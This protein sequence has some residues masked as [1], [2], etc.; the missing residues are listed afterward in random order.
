MKQPARSSG[1]RALGA[2][3]WERIDGRV[4]A[5]IEDV[6][7]RV[8]GGEAPGASGGAATA[9]AV[10]RVVGETVR[11]EA[12]VFA[13]G[14]DQLGVVI[15]FQ[16]SGGA[17]SETAMRA[18]G[19]DRW[20]GEF[21]V[22]AEGAHEFK[23]IAWVDHFKTWRDDLRKRAEAGQ[24]LSVEFLIGAAFV[25]DAAADSRAAGGEMMAFAARL[26]DDESDA[27]ARLGAALD[28]RLAA[29][30]LTHAPRRFAVES[31][32]V[33]VWVDRAK[34]RFSSWYE[35]FPRSAGDGRSHGTMRDVIGRLDRVAS[36]GFDVLYM[37]PIHPIGR[38]F[39]KGKNNTLEPGADD[40]GSP[41]AIGG[42]QGGHDAI[43]PDLGTEADFDE[44]IREAGTRGIE[45]AMDLA[46]QCS[47]DHPY[48]RAHPEWF[49]RRPD[50]SIQYAENPPKKYQ[51][52]YPFEFEC[53]AWRDLWSE[54]RRVVLHWAERGVRIFRV[55]NP[56]TKP[57]ALWQWLI[58]QVKAEHPDVLFLAEAFTRPKVMHRLG[59]VGFTQSYTYFAWRH[60]PWELREYFTELTQTAAAE[61]FR[62]NA[63]P[64]TPDI[65][66]EYLQQG[67]RA[68]FVTRA[69]L[70]ATLCANWGVYGPAFELMEHLPAKPGSEEYLD[71]EKYQIREWE[72]DRR[73]SLAPLL[74]MLN[75]IRR[76]NAALQ[77]DRTLRFHSC[78]NPAIVCYSK[79]AGESVIV[80]VAN[81]DP[82]NVQWGTVDLDLS[83]LGVPVDR[84]YQMHDLLTGS[85]YRWQGW[86]NVVGLD[87]STTPAHLFRVRR[88]DRT[89]AQFEYFL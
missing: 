71:S 88:H 22:L 28:E 76:D 69:I 10:K 29:L 50:G 53:E 27:G 42:A 3:V 84:P 80:V 55:D 64:N 66:T 19:N 40:V 1:A 35:L 7:P 13:D 74:T 48:V 61:Y 6:R 43:H 67:N 65:L 32:A 8:D 18:I 82:H 81:T 36:M 83:A 62:P 11:V 20:A 59:K 15:Q 34:A 12:D 21:E 57:F 56:H 58:S 30:M 14:H 70:A 79:R 52:I 16:R 86:K 38:A 33:G 87:P 75:R 63:W 68:A 73:D 45:V 31:P 2:A 89:E 41:W 9:F 77:Q 51:D 85:R 26:R 37:P 39:R 44:L 23:V 5:V 46:L 17:P 4:R 54:I 72:W 47:P 60:G 49:R 25:E 24:D 78:D